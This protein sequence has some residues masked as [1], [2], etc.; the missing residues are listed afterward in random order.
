MEGETTVSDQGTSTSDSP[1]DTDPWYKRLD[2]NGN[3]PR[4]LLN[5]KELGPNDKKYPNPDYSRYSSV[6]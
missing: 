5:N 1:M 6:F 2:V 3:V 4:N